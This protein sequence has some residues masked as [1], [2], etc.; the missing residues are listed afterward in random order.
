[1]LE[2]RGSSPLLTAMEKQAV[3]AI[4]DKA[5]KK[6]AF[7]TLFTSEGQIRFNTDKEATVN[8]EDTHL[9]VILDDQTIPVDDK[10]LTEVVDVFSHL[11]YTNIQSITYYVP[12]LIQPVPKGKIVGLA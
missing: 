7:L 9:E 11:E 6:K 10:G 3:Q 2:D 12:R 8:Y 1:M 5:F 4:I